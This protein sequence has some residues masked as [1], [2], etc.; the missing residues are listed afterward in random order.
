MKGVV[1]MDTLCLGTV[2]TDTWQRLDMVNSHDTA[3]NST[4]ESLEIVKVD[5][6]VLFECP[7]AKVEKV[8]HPERLESPCRRMYRVNGCFVCFFN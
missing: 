3:M 7:G 5:H 1:F 8:L 2:G 6:V 4:Q